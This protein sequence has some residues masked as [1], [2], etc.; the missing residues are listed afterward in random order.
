[1][2]R[3]VDG[4]TSATLKH[5]RERWWDASFTNFLRDNLHP[6]AG[7]R[8]LDVG[9]GT[10]TAELSLGL[11]RLS[12]VELVGID[13]VV[14]RVREAR[15]ATRARNLAV[16]FA[17]ADA[18]ALPF[19]DESFESTFC[20]A[21]LQHIRD[22]PGALREF[23]RVTK[24]GGRILAVEPD[25]AARYWYSSL[26]SGTRAFE[27]GARF[28]ATLADARGDTTDLAVG[29]HLPGLFANCGIEP[30]AVHLFPVSVSRL[31]APPPPIW[32]SRREAIRQAVAK[33]PDE[34]LRRLGADYL[35][36]IERYAEE[37][38][39]AGPTFVE[40]QNTM[41]FATV[42]QRPEN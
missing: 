37:A 3:D 24:P 39:A 34:A 16:R 6:R 41:L 14:E 42:G 36:V 12:Q 32:E 28:F 29:P 35:R 1:M 7:N 18:C 22:I 26:E 9:C 10:G 4:L 20:V 13:L 25:N 30:L 8:I 19:R 5:L 40:I 17:A 11:L 31:G 33:A 38:Q 15:A 21:V 27:L 2:P 23:V